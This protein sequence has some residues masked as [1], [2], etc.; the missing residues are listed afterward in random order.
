MRLVP[1]KDIPTLGK[2]EAVPSIRGRVVNIYARNA[3]TNVHGEYSLQNLTIR[4]ETGEATIKLKDRPELPLT[5][6]G[7]VIFIFSKQGDKG[8]TGLKVKDDEYPKGSGKVTRIVSVTPTATIQESDA[9]HDQPASRPAQNGANGHA[10]AQRQPATP[11]RTAPAVSDNDGPPLDSYD[12]QP[13]APPAD[14]PSTQTAAP[15]SQP[16]ATNGHKPAAVS[17]PAKVRC[18]EIRY[19]VTV[20]TGNYC[21]EKIGVTL[22]LEEGVTADEGL[23]LAKKFVAAHSAKQGVN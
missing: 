18:I 21:S 6:K 7:K 17:G 12:A 4:D 2:D 8:L 23:E 16:K 1:L 15:A 5:T 10:P 3:G 20:N 14:K 22:A 19:D 13:E 9:A 11:P